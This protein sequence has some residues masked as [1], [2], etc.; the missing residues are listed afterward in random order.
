MKIWPFPCLRAIIG[1]PVHLSTQN[2]FFGKPFAPPWCRKGS[3][4]YYYRPLI[5]KF[6]STSPPLCFR[7]WQ[8][9]TSSNAMVKVWAK[10]ASCSVF[11]CTDDHR[12]L[13]RVLVLGVTREQWIYWF[14]YCI[15]RCCHT[16]LI[17]ANT[18]LIHKH[19]ISF[20]AV[21]LHR[22]NRLFL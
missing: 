12:T 4:L 13:F 17:H 7:K 14:I 21:Y 2:C 10:H 19:A 9:C 20:P 5:C 8:W 1:S 15:L 16:D 11:G 18:D 3:L 22:H 6:P